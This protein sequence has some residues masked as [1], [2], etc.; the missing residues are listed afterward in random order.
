[1]YAVQIPQ[2]KARFEEQLA[3]HPDNADLARWLELTNGMLNGSIDARTGRPPLFFVVRMN[4]LGV[5][6]LKT[7]K[8]GFLGQLQTE[9]QA[10]A[11]PPENVIRVWY[12][13]PTNS[14]PHCG[15]FAFFVGRDVDGGMEHGGHTEVMSLCAD[16]PHVSVVATSATHPSNIA[17][18]VTSNQFLQALRRFETQPTAKQWLAIARQLLSGETQVSVRPIAFV[19]TS[20]GPEGQLGHVVWRVARELAT[21]EQLRIVPADR[22]IALKDAIARPCRICGADALVVGTETIANDFDATVFTRIYTLCIAE[23]HAVEIATAVYGG[24]M[25]ITS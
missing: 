22:F 13:G 4:E 11:R 3:L 5:G 9:E 20:F 18:M 24:A 21:E 1:M 17:A 16:Q 14:C 15:N 25:G 12:S 6:Q 7:F 19:T 8:W 2:I 23:P 10:R